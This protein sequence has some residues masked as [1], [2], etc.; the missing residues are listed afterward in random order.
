M[1]EGWDGH[2]NTLEND[3]MAQDGTYTW[4]IFYQDLED[5]RHRAKAHVNLLK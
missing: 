2:I 4:V 5:K 1:D 3:R